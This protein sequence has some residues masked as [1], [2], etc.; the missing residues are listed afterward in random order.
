MYGVV[1]GPYLTKEILNMS[2]TKRSSGTKEETSPV[3]GPGPNI[4]GLYSK[5]SNSNAKPCP[6]MKHTKDD[7]YED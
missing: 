5:D 3:V 2:D 7:D 4:S 6:Q 1:C